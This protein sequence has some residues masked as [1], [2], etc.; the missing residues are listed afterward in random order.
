LI[1]CGLF[2][3]AAWARYVVTPE[4]QGRNVVAFGSGMIDTTGLRSRG[5]NLAFPI[6][7]RLAGR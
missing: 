1:S 6:L 3:S 4:Q 7:R 2:A 5:S